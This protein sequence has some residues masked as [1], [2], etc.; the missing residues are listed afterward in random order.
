MAPYESFFKGKRVTILGLGLLGRSVGDAAFIAKCGGRVTVT[1]LKTHEELVDSVARLEGLGVTFHLGGHD[2]Q[3]FTETDMVI[4]SAGVRLDS[5][6]IA[7][8]RAAGV[9]VYMST[10]L[11]AKFAIEAGVKVVGV[12]GTRGK[13]TVAHMIHHALVVSGRRAHLGGNIRGISTLAMLHNF[14]KD[15]TLVL[16]LDSWQLQGFGDLKLSPHVGIFTNLMP[17][18]QN[19]YPDMN[20]YFADKANIFRFQKQGDTL[21]ATPELAERIA[22]IGAGEDAY[23]KHIESPAPKEW[24]LT[25]PGEHNRVNVALAVAAL[26]AL[27]LPPEEIRSGLESF[28]GVEGRLQFV[29]EIGGVKIYNDNN[30]TTPEATIAALQALNDGFRK[31]VILIMGGADKGLDA[32]ALVD[33]INRSCKAVVFLAGSG[34]DAVLRST[35]YVLRTDH[36]DPF[37]TLQAAVNRALTLAAPSDIIL[38]SPGFASFGMFKNEYD[39]ND[40]LLQ[41]VRSMV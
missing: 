16:E 32:H 1:D 7:A 39:R 20:T 34:T 3:D 19:Y 23:R 15:D 9:P 38:F 24:K 22:G 40:Q 30:A 36:S 8:S 2:S 37:D 10:A 29:R 27:G 11:A 4:K 18:H 33:E 21:I 26:E 41:V 12:T 25:M 5:R 35:S 13:S 31:S 28:G 17:D 6:E 14:K